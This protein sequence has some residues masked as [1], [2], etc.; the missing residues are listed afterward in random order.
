MTIFDT[1]KYPISDPPTKAELA[2][3]PEQLFRDWL[4]EMNWSLHITPRI[5]AQYYLSVNH[6]VDVT[7]LQKMKR[8]ITILR[9]MIEDYEPL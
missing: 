7:Q 6:R 3:L 9:K 8:D 1:I 5:I 4:K 2:A